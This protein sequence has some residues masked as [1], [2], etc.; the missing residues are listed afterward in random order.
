M[1]YFEYAKMV[2]KN[3]TPPMLAMF[4]LKNQAAVVHIS[5][6]D[7]MRPGS[8]RFLCR[9]TFLLS[10]FLLLLLNCTSVPMLRVMLMF[11]DSRCGDHF[12]IE[13]QWS[14]RS[15]ADSTDDF[16]VRTPVTVSAP[17]PRDLK[18]NGVASPTAVSLA[19]HD[20]TNGAGNAV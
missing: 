3:M 6:L 12:E 11:I 18:E 5:S 13:K 17:A 19:V 10:T 16:E 8:P 14:Y 1:R 20:A 15:S 7:E 2:Q 9:I 4:F